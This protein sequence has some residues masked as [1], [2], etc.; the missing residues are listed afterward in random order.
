MNILINFFASLYDGVI[1]FFASL[2]DLVYDFII[3]LR[4]YVKW[5]TNTRST[6]S[7][8][9]NTQAEEPVRVDNQTPFGIR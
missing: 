1:V 4:E 2:Y 5:T 6:K 3:F 7:T 8:D 9:F